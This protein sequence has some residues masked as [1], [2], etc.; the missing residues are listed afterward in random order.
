MLY[1]RPN[2]SYWWCQFTAP[3]G[4]RIRQSTKTV[5][6]QQA[7]EFADTLKARNWRILRLGEK[8][9]RSWK[10]AAVKWFKETER[11]S[12]QDALDQIK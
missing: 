3:N 12:K 1:K 8:P 11:R 10:E 9:R 6:K 4:R 5:D 7:Q 2:S